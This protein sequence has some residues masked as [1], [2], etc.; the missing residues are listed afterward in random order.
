MSSSAGGGGGDPSPRAPSSR[1][2]GVP[3]WGSDSDQF[4]LDGPRGSERPRGAQ[5]G[6]RGRLWQP[7][8]DQRE[9]LAA[10]RDIVRQRGEVD[11]ASIQVSRV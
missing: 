11:G 8:W 6:G 7:D 10:A 2:S 9:I 4:L 3:T 1:V 5:A